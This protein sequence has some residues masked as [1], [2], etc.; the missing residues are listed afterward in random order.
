MSQ[1]SSSGDDLSSKNEEIQEIAARGEPG[2]FDTHPGVRVLI[3]FFLTFCLFLFL[4]FQE[5]HVEIPE[6]NSK[7]SNY[8]VAQVD[9]EFPD[10]ETTLLLKQEAARDIGKIYKVNPKEIEERREE[11]EKFLIGDQSWRKIAERSTFQEMYQA[12][13]MLE[14]TLLKIR[15][16]DARTIQKIKEMRLSEG[17]Y[18]LF[19]PPD[20][21]NQQVL[22]PDEL[23]TYLRGEAFAKSSFQPGTVDFVIDYFK[24]R[25]WLLEQDAGLQKNLQKLARSMVP[26]KFTRVHAGNSIIKQ[27]EKVT[28]RHIAMLQAMKQTLGEQRNLWHP[29]T[30]LGSFIIALLFTLVGALYVKS[31]HPELYG[32][33][34]QLF[35]LVTVVVLTLILAKI[36][37]FLLLKSNLSELVRFPVLAPFAAILLCSLFNPRVAIFASGFISIVLSMALAIDRNGY[38]LINFLASMVA[39]LNIRRLHKRK[40]V[41]LVCGKAWACCVALVIGIDL[42]TMGHWS[43]FI[44]ADIISTFLFMSLIGIL[45]MGFLPLLESAFHVMTDISLMEYMDPSNE[46]LRRLSIE[47][48]GTYQ[49]SIV[50]GNLAEAAALAI[51]AN[52]LFCRVSTQYHDIGKLIAPQY[53]TENQQGGVNMH[54]LL[55]PVESAQV[56][57]SHVSEGVS[58]ARK[59]GL[60]EPFISI[61]KEHHGN[62]LVYYFYTKECEIHEGDKTQVDEKDFRYMGP[63]PRTRESAII[64]IA[65]SLEAASR[66]LDEF[67]PEAVTT[68]VESLIAEKTEDGQFDECQLTFEELGIVKKTLIKTLVAAGHSRIK[69]PGK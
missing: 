8:V 33:N 31:A 66:S 17:D 35:L 20:E 13:N 1:G 49:H 56:I 62:T 30:L 46:L 45:V 48:P 63:K 4:H 54:Q 40:E 16:T 23:W 52:G 57:I 39:V 55:T 42:Y 28:S 69:Y 21:L 34:K 7:A 11:F 50:V 51:G 27:G 65:D 19:I 18:Q 61:I 15:Y 36:I 26:Q 44:V 58:M 2:F 12:A 6:L 10:D 43:L 47:A 41:F 24:E 59:A 14:N 29:I 22:L 38:F 3:G 25:G 60:P 32:S 68:L 9:F 37:E 67:T 53:F 5:V 64:M